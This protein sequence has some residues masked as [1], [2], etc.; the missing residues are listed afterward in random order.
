LEVCFTNADSVNIGAC[1]FSICILKQKPL[2]EKKKQAK[3]RKK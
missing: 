1:G 2:K 3:G